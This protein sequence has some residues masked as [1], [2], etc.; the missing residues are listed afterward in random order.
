MV[1]E[2]LKGIEFDATNTRR[3]NSKKLYG[4]QRDSEALLVRSIL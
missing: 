1:V 3:T 2:T 4:W